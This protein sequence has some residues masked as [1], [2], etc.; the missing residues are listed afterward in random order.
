MGRISYPPGPRPGNPLV[1]LWRLR[2]DPATYLLELQRHYGNA[3]HLRLARRH[4]YLFNEPEAVQEVLVTRHRAFVKGQILRQA[5]SVLGEGLLTSEGAFHL[6]QR[7]LLQPAFHRQRI[8]SYGATM[9]EYAER[10]AA[11]W[12]DGA[13]FDAAQEMARLTLAVVG[14][15]L[16]DADVEADAPEVGEA[17]TELLG[18]ST[19]PLLPVIQRLDW[20]PLPPLRRLVASRARLHGIVDRL[21]ADHRASGDRGDMLSMLLAARDEDGQ[22]MPDEQVRAEAMTLFL[23]G[24]ETTA[25]ALA[26]TWLLL[27][28][29]PEVEARLHAEVDAVLGGRLPTVDDV[30]RL[31]YTRQVL[32]ESMRLYPPAWTLARRAVEEVEIVGWRVP[33]GS[34]VLLSQFVLHRDPRFYPQ[35]ERF[36]PDR[37]TP[38]AQA[39]RPRYA[40]FPFGAGN[41]ICIG[42][43]F[44]WLEGVLVLAT[45][46]RHWRLRLAPGHRT[47][48]QALITLRPRHGVR[49]RA[50]RRRAEPRERAA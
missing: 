26:W 35:P 11:R 27:A 29:H 21:I 1:S 37:W 30:P 15:T 33:A 47:A 12:T 7:R 48:L 42:E 5:R 10:T 3:V 22:P 44:A 20:L 39:A 31:T 6:R 36:D 49:V 28:Q 23:A 4:L 2:R 17:L 46:A 8:A 13:T 14:K 34:I 41:R 9:A 18:W 25:N 43:A 24:H 16:F 38:E 50:E 40:Y 45:I 32:A 19:S